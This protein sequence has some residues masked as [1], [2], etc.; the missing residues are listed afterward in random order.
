MPW[1]LYSGKV[2]RIY[3]YTEKF[4]SSVFILTAI[5]EHLV[6]SRYLGSPLNPILIDGQEE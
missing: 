1:T 2:S 4:T 5:S 6:S 3:G